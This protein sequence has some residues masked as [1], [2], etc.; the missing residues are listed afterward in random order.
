M[1]AF[2]LVETLTAMLIITTVI[3]GP[4]TVAMNAATYARQTKDIMIATY[5]AQESTELIH[6]LQDSLYIKCLSDSTGATCPPDTYADETYK[7]PNVLAWEMLKK[8][9]DVNPS[10]TV[11]CFASAGVG[12]NYDFIGITGNENNSTV[13]YPVKYLPT[14]IS[15]NNLKL[16]T[17]ER[18]Y[19]CSGANNSSTGT[20]TSFS[21]TVKVEIIDTPTGADANYNDG[22]RVT[23]T[24]TFRRSNGYIRTVKLVDFLHP[25][26]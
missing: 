16:L 7:E 12:C 23:S 4:L 18:L 3:L 14:D 26:T 5:L 8:D 17:V 1:K 15:C 6:H 20:E 2:T 22:L 13:S 19:V 21:R 10:S 11:S 25:H 24:V 9:L